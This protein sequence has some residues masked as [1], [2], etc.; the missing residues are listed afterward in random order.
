MPTQ[1]F[2]DG[3]IF[4][5]IA[6]TSAGV[7]SKA[8]D[9][10][11]KSAP[12]LSDTLELSARVGMK[13]HVDPLLKKFPGADTRFGQMIRRIPTR[14][15]DTIF[16]YG[17]EADKKGGGGV[18]GP[19]IQAAL[20]WAKTQHGLPYQWGGNGNPS[21]DCSGFLSAIESK[22]RGQKPHRRWATG[23]FS[24]RT[25]PPGWVL[26]GKSPFTIGITNDGVGHTAGTL[27]GVNVEC[28]GGDGVVVG[29]RAR[30]AQAIM[31]QDV[32][33]FQPGKYDAGGYLQPGLNLAYNGTG[34][35]EP[36]FTSQ[37]AN[38][39]SRMAGASGLGD[40]SVSVFVGNEEISHIARA[41]V[42]AANGELLSTVRAG[43]RGV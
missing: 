8:W 37:Q 28:R 31:F 21:W 17:K 6:K 2:A 10:V 18:G 32:Y 3:G 41:E 30:G 14:M 11:K 27:G 42:R 26:N 35:P 24:G 20:K 12:W 29:K 43:R 9:V 5:W 22:I 25:A 15:L 38:A 1:R 19:K 4:G 39:L 23:A 33:G 16:G 13:Q 36:V 40:L 34:R 7:G